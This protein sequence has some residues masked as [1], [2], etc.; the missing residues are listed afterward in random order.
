VPEGPRGVLF[1]AGPGGA[2]EVWT[3][4]FALTH[5]LTLSTGGLYL[6]CSS[7]WPVSLSTGYGAVFLDLPWVLFG[8][9]LWVTWAAGPAILLVLGL[10]SL[11]RQRRLSWR[12]ATAWLG[13]LA[14]GTATGYL[15]FGYYSLLFTSYT[16]DLD[17]TPLGDS[18]F[19]PAT[20]FWPALL[21]V[22]GQ[23]AVCAGLIALI[24]AWPAT[25]GRTGPPES[26]S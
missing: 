10:V 26:A 7:I 21:A 15:I 5:A 4:A 13:L 17:G 23:L 20:P 18:R 24:S 2:T 22:G 6:F 19:A 14:G 3:I 1:Y 16:P 9:V 11:Y 25:R 12:P 8:L